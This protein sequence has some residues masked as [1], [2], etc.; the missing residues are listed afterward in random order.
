[1]NNKNKD[2]N[3]NEKLVKFVEKGL[4]EKKLI[5]GSPDQVLLIAPELLGKSL[6]FQLN[7]E[8]SDIRIVL[9]KEKLNKHPSLIIWSIESI[10]KQDYWKKLA[11]NHFKS[12]GVPH[13][14]ID[15]KN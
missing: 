1:M 10:E 11:I 8:L 6:S 12:I 7:A 5:K 4:L 2:W 3:T 9:S 14:H 13:K 15:A